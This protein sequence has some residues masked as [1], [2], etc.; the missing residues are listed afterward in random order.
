[1][2]SISNFRNATTESY[3][4]NQGA[5]TPRE[6]SRGS[7]STL[8]QRALQQMPNTYQQMPQQQ[9][10]SYQ[11]QIQQQQQ[12]P[13]DIQS[14]ELFPSTTSHMGTLNEATTNTVAQLP[15][16]TITSQ[17][18]TSLSHTF[19]QGNVTQSPRSIR[20]LP[21]VVQQQANSK[22][23]KV[24]QSQGFKFAPP[25]QNYNLQQCKFTTNNFKV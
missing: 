15:P 22:S 19:G 17:N 3:D 9:D 10:I 11:Q 16:P 5:F 4:A 7:R 6:K 12:Y 25:V 21:P 13:M 1:M 2:L 8:K 23:Y 20:P 18:L 24:V 14:V